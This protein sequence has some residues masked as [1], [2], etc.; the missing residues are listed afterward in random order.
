MW[1]G[2]F[3]E[4]IKGLMETREE[5][6]IFIKYAVAVIFVGSMKLMCSCKL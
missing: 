2:E 5:A 1:E 4:N 6:I 3:D